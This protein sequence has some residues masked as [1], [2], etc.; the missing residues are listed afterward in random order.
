MIAP[1]AEVPAD[2]LQ[3]ADFTRPGDRRAAVLNAELAVQR[4]LMRLDGI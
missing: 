2:V 3:Q 1:S 4:S